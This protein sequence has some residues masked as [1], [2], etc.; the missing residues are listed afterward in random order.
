MNIE[1][2]GDKAIEK[3]VEGGKLLSFSDIF[4]LSQLDIMEM[5]R[6][7]EKS[8]HNILTSI[9]NSKKT[10]LA[11]FIYAL[12]IRFVGE[13]TARHLA[14]HFGSIDRFLGATEEE[15]LK[16]TEVGPKIAEAILT[17]IKDSNFKMEIEKLLELGVSLE[18]SSVT[19]NGKLSG[20]TFLITGTL[21]IGRDEA[22]ELIERNGGK[23]LSGV[24]KKLNFLIVGEEPGSKAEKAQD[25]GVKIIS[26]DQLNQMLID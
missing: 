20:F 6:Q 13:Q 25:L 1:K 14:A 9:E 2:L 8:A 18:T 23:F 17:S 5:E 21:P 16:V 24:S 19:L 22:R 7:G 4:R 26:W 15:L 10:T 12:G 11:R 3:L